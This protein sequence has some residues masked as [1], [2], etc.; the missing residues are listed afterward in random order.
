MKNVVSIT[1]GEIRLSS[2]L[3]EY[4]FGKTNFNSI[5]TE[6]G[7]IATCDSKDGEPLHFSFEKWTFAEI[8]SFEVEGFDERIVF[9]CNKNPLTKNAQT[10]LDLYAKCGTSQATTTDKDN[11]YLAS[12]AYCT[13]LTQAANGEVELPLNGSGGVLVDGIDSAKKLKFLF[14]PQNIFKYSIAGLSAVEQADLHNCWINPSL[15]D[16]PAICFTRSCVAYKMLTGRYPYPSADNLTRNADLL[17]RN[18]L[19]LELSINGINKELAAA[20]NNGLKLNSNSVNIP[21]KKAKGKRSEDLVPQKDFPLE[22]LAN[23]KENLSTN[24]SD[25]AFEEK[26]NSYKKLQNS[27]VKTKRT[28]RRNTTAFLAGLIALVVVI[29]YARSSYISYLND[30][31]TKGLT[32]VQTIQTFFKGINTLDIPLMQTF[33][34]GKSAN[35]Y[36]DSVSNVYVI[37]KQR[38][39]N[40]DDN[41]FQKPAR[42]FVMLTNSSMLSMIGLYGVTN[43][44]ID[45]KQYDEYL[46]LKLNKEQPEIITQEQGVTINKGDK[47]VHSVEYYT[48]HSEGTNNDIY[49]TKNKDTFTLTFKKN[50][51]IITDI[52]TSQTDISL[53]SDL[54]KSEYF[55]LIIQNDGDAVKTINQMSF[56]Y[57]FLPTEKE[58]TVEKKAFEDYLNDPYKGIF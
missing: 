15:H 10:L 39:S 34:N 48:L 44:K 29:I 35:R 32:S 54:F 51:W 8:K 42:F 1:D 52:E 24:L 19:P 31:T 3:D 26:V 2:G 28:L 18:F 21:G 23:A 11:M 47:S 33:V 5:V 41:G 25:E 55:N 58:M 12:L 45:G 4:K 56:K 43:V 37:S 49:V 30:Y 36:L 9:Y 46:D 27:K 17:D 53:D 14:L 7:I 50:K 38:Q 6:E 40:G 16:L 57:D 22:L 13:I 20:V